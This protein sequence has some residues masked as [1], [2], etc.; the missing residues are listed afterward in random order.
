MGPGGIDKFG[1]AWVLPSKCMNL[2]GFQ[3]V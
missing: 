3:D 1:S 2:L